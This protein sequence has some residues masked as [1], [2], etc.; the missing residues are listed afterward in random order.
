[1]PR[2]IDFGK[3]PFDD[4]YLI[5]ND[6][7]KSQEELNNRKARLFPQG[8]TDTE[9]ATTSI[10][11]SSLG[12]VKEY[13]E[14]LLCNIGVNKIK[15]KNVSLHVY[16]E[17]NSSTKE[18]RPDGLIV[19]TSGKSNPIIEWAAFV[20]VKTNNNLIEQ[21]QID[22]YIE[23]AKT[24]GIESIITISNQLVTSPTDSVV[25][26][27][28]NKFSL[29]HWSWTY[30][31]VTAR[32]LI[33]TNSVE[34]LDHIYILEELRR[35]LDA[36]KNVSNYVNMGKGW[37]EITEKVN[38]LQV[39]QKIPEDILNPLVTSYTQEEKDISLQL[40]D[41]SPLHVTLSAKK[42]RK[43]TIIN[44]L[45]KSKTISTDFVIHGTKKTFTITT[46]FIRQNVTCSTQV[47]I[48]SGKSQAQTTALIKSL[49][50][51]AGGT[52]RIIVRALYA[53]NKS[54]NDGYSLQQLIDD[55]KRGDSYSILDKSIGDSVKAFEITTRD[56]LGRDF[57]NPR[58]FI[59]SLEGIANR[60]LTQVMENI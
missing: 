15:N 8:N 53:R 7:F 28:K 25:Q 17:I 31:R 43:V 47:V 38:Q 36:H 56:K 30:L 6:N 20:E 22:R 34:D 5:L 2:T 13:R 41:N 57:S 12:A 49:E 4:L 11:L 19:L 21:G 55:R 1:M 60:F 14:E 52:D 29:S 32:R 27:R 39:D 26:T 16:T 42:D 18:D 46:D 23:F 59:A 40:T 24:V 33:R 58:K 10:F 35:Y 3:T 37:R 48:S 50:S 9:Q 54:A 45:S 44:S 51:D